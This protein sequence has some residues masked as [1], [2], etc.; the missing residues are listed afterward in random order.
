MCGQDVTSATRALIALAGA[1]LLLGGCESSPFAGPV[2]PDFTSYIDAAVD[3]EIAGLPPDARL[4]TQRET[5]D[6]EITLEDVREEL[7]AIGPAT[8]AN[9][10]EITLGP[11]L[12]GAPQ[13]RIIIRL[14]EAL[15]T[16]VNNNL[17][18]DVARVQPAINREDVINAEAAFDFVLGAGAS[19]NRIDQPRTTPFVVAQPIGVPV[20][21]SENYRFDTSLTKRLHSGTVVEL[22]SNL[23][24]FR[25]RAPGIAFFPDPAYTADV[26]LG[27]VQPL[28]RGFGSEVNT[29]SIRL[30]QNAAKSTVAQLTT[31]LLDL[32]EQMEEAYWELVTRWKDLE[33]LQW[34]VEEGIKVREV[35]EGRRDFDANMAQRADAVAR[36]EQRK[37]NVIRGRRRVRAA[38]DRLKLL[39]NDPMLAMGSE[40]VLYPAARERDTPIE[41]DLR[42]S[43]ATA[44]DNR[45]EIE[46]A[47]LAIDDSAI[48]QLVADN[49]RLPLLDLSG[50]IAYVGLNTN[51]GAAYRALDDD[52]IDYVLALSFE[53]PLG[54]RA[55]EADY[56]IARLRRYQ[57]LLSYRQAVQSVVFDVKA[58]LRDVVANYE[59]IQATRAFRIAQ[60]ENLRTLL[61]REDTMEGLTPEFLNLKFDRQDRLASA[62]QQEIT[63]LAN[64]DNSLSKLY[65]AM[66]TG[67]SMRG[68]EVEMVGEEDVVDLLRR[69]GGDGAGP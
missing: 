30:A 63:A 2:R 22:S 6:I 26:R 34:L 47:L 20:N 5:S 24:R 43:I 36:V 61:V 40:A 29:A 1:A 57:T 53:Y 48:R 55:A 37:S 65:R 46:Q 64:H 68:I 67:L 56:R 13:E 51:A 38:S 15:M 41:Y 4:V 49:A 25:N 16:A 50:E 59:L 69:E 33:I 35:L 39:M 28:L 11:D 23:D 8:T 54:N 60:A 9:R 12:T 18:V 17:T 21:A 45:P 62:R 10:T 66:G 19:L 42:D 32:T 14:E 3:R 44:L 7:E 31:E 52:F 27:V 58:A